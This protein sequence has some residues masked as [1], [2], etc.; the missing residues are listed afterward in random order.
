MVGWL[1]VTEGARAP[2]AMAAT[3]AIVFITVL[4]K[5]IGESPA[6]PRCRYP[7]ANSS[8][9]RKSPCSE[10]TTMASPGPDPTPASSTAR[11]HAA[12]VRRQIRESRR[13]SAGSTRAASRASSISAASPLVPGS[14][15]KP[16]SG[17]IPD[18]PR[19]SASAT[20]DV[21]PEVSALTVP[22]PVMTTR[23]RSGPARTSRMSES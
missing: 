13:A 7:P 8:L 1:S 17:P 11:R 12:T 14:G 20:A 3:E 15:T 2:T 22:I 9:E 16:R 23:R 10:P 19:A 6:G 4:G 5:I 18:R 21:P